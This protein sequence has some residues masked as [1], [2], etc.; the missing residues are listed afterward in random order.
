MSLLALALAA[1]SA[2]GASV[3][4]QN[5]G[6]A[7]FAV[8]DAA[9]NMGTISDVKVTIDGLRVR[10]A[11]GMW[12]NVNVQQQTFGLL[13]LR[14]RGVTDLLANA[15]LNAGTYDRLE[16]DVSKAVVIDD[17]GSHEAKLP[18]NTLQL[19]GTMTVVP[20]ATATADFDFLT[21]KSL[22]VTGNGTYVFAPV[23][24]VQTRSSADV[25]IGSDRT[26]QVKGGSVS[27]D[28]E[29]GMDVNGNV[30]AGFQISPDAVLSVSASG[31]IVQTAGPAL[32]SGTI[33]AVD[34]GA[35]TVT[36]LTKSGQDITLRLASAGG[37]LIDGS[38]AA[39]S[40]LQSAVGSQV[41][42][43]YDA[44]TNTI[45]SVTVGDAGANAGGSVA[46]QGG[47]TASAQATVKGTLKAVDIASGT[48]TV[49]IDTG[50][51]LVLKVGSD[52]NVLLDGA[53]GGL[54]GLS[55]KV[56]SNATVSYD[57][58]TKVA[59]IVQVES[60]GSASAETTVTGTLKSVD[61]ITGA[62]T[63]AT[64]T[65]ASLVLDV[66][67]SANIIASGSVSTIASLTAYVGSQVTV[68]YD[69]N[70]KVA[71]NIET[72]GGTSGTATASSSASVSGTLTAVDFLNGSLTIATSAGRE[73]TLKVVSNTKV[74]VG[75]AAVGPTALATKVGSSVTAQYDAE[76]HTATS[77]SIG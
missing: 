76:T 13:D 32:V 69:A 56:G 65:G 43:G 35:G 73:I 53:A 24:H 57:T 33:K 44:A 10:E 6:S 42:V 28:T 63:I 7:V 68:T 18:G 27:T 23:L 67:S 16:L 75:D 74:T 38:N 46:A 14:N 50:A 54:A 20:G 17:K 15:Q 61:S 1:C 19:V 45:A 29:L 22:H 31:K 40:D 62:I 72:S 37:V 39:A 58:E 30:G 12:T 25:S 11:S 48:I 8:S 26:V 34:L 3:T 2:P 59:N 36:V 60:S 47:A 41:N 21:D 5:K 64:T 66:S 70:T 49:A 77:V 4:E 51:Q 71:S 9:A 55:A 52:T